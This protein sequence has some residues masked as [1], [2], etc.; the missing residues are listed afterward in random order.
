MW[1]V[2][3]LGDNMYVFADIP[4]R[5]ENWDKLLNSWWTKYK[6]VPPKRSN[7]YL[8]YIAVYVVLI[9][10]ANGIK[11]NVILAILIETNVSTYF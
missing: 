3:I 1:A 11:K 6:R 9:F 5:M 4:Q 7:N 10:Q 8:Y 2:S